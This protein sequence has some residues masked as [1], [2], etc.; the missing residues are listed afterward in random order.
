VVLA[1]VLPAVLYPT[2]SA[3]LIGL[4]PLGSLPLA[5]LTLVLMYPYI[6]AYR[7]GRS[8][9]Q[10]LIAAAAVT[11]TAG[12]AITLATFPELYADPNLLL[13][14]G[15]IVCASLLSLHWMWS[16]TF[17]GVLLDRRPIF[18]V[19]DELDRCSPD[20][21]VKLLHSIHTLM[22][23]EGRGYKRG[24]AGSLLVLVL[25]ESR[26]LA[27][28]FE[29]HY[30]DVNIHNLASEPIGAN[31]LQKIVDHSV[32]VPNLTPVQV[33]VMVDL[34]T[35]P[36]MPHSDVRYPNGNGGTT[37]SIRYERSREARERAIKITREFGAG[38]QRTDE[39]QNAIANPELLPSDR[40][41]V[42]MERVGRE[43]GSEETEIRT[44]HLLGNYLEIMPPNPRQIRRIANCWGMLLALQS[45]LGRDFDPDVLVRAAVLYVRFPSVYHKIMSANRAPSLFPDASPESAIRNYPGSVLAEGLDQAII[46]VVTRAD[47]A[48]IDLSEIAACYGCR[49]PDSIG[50]TSAAL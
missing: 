9:G 39:V 6:A 13:T 15:A 35:S 33:G 22:R 18:L 30:A 45:H 38:N 44:A 21:V 23:T 17:S 37:P 12:S 27:A 47:G 16:R 50:R 20:R 31:F 14:S 26:W 5:A 2:F 10:A 3:E 29:A 40:V 11:L 36:M 46:A 25:A 8:L 28:S 24:R 7:R 1:Q 4:R 32:I 19:V 41:A 34:A 42:E 48:I 43:A 49:Y